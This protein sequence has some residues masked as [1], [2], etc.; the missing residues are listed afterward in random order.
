MYN[1]FMIALMVFRDYLRWHYARAFSDIFTIWRNITHFLFHFFSISML[2][3]T[4]FS[5]W[6]RIEADRETQ[7]FDP[8]D[9]LSTL[10]VNLIMRLVGAVMRS[11]L[12]AIGLAFVGLSVVAGLLF[13][14]VWAILPFL[15]GVI[16]AA[17]V[18]LVIFG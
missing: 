8:K 5:P 7:G 2:A 18:T 3:R 16:V 14:A 9:Y 1:F 11:V 15:I 13:F 4:L 12:I 17:G 6:K 10:L